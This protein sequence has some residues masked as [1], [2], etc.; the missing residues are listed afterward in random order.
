MPETPELT[1]AEKLTALGTYIKTLQ[2]IEKEMRAAVTKDMGARKVERVGAYLGPVKIGTVGY[3]D[4]RRTVH[5]NDAEALAWC[6]R[7]HPGEVETVER[8]RPAFMDKLTAVAASLPLGYG[9]DPA[10]GEQLRFI[11]IVRGAP[12]VTVATTEEGV[13][14]M[15]A[16]ANGF[17]AMLGSFSP[18]ATAM[19]L[20]DRLE[21]GAHDR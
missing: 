3:S 19:A 15:E 6:R 21:N 20:A 7:T 13:E 4:G 8:V 11:E 5:V 17:S 12:Y 18:S 9:L 10:T 14:R 16:I 2:R 1:D